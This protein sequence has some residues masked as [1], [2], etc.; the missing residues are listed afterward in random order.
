MSARGR[1]GSA[2]NGTPSGVLSGTQD[3]APPGAKP[4]GPPERTADSLAEL[5]QLAWTA[6]AEVV[7]T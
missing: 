7:G 4:A 2:P 5:E 1:D 3:G 6:G